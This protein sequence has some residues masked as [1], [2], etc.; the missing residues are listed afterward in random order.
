MKKVK[1]W[2]FGML[3]IFWISSMAWAAE[4]LEPC[5]ESSNPTPPFN[6]S[7]KA[8]SG[9]PF[10]SSNPEENTGIKNQPQEPL[11]PSLMNRPNGK[12]EKG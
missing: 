3:L 1:K 8:A 9:Q 2:V 10:T 6:E 7:Q 12:K 5:P 4:R 11:I